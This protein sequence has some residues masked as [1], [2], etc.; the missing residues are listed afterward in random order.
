MRMLS[1]G[2]FLNTQPYQ[3]LR[4]KPQV[5]PMIAALNCGK[6]FREHGGSC[7]GAKMMSPN[8]MICRSGWVRGKCSHANLIWFLQQVCVK[9]VSLAL[10]HRPWTPL[11]SRNQLSGDLQHTLIGLFT[12]KWPF[13]LELHVLKLLTGDLWALSPVS[14]FCP[15]KSQSLWQGS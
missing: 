1:G 3:G 4:K 10:K 6:N 5:S 7:Q 8:L 2:G 9:C 11:N 12:L 14:R 15:I 13:V